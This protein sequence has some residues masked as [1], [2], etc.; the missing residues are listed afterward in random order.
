MLTYNVMKNMVFV[1]FINNKYINCVLV[2]FF[3]IY[4]TKLSIVQRKLDNNT[5]FLICLIHMV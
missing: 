3:I 5:I 2:V 1:V 4:K